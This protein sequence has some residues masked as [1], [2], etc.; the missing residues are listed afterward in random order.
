GDMAQ[1]LA[2]VGPVGLQESLAQRRRHHA[3]LGLGDI[4][5]SIAHPMHAGAVEEPLWQPDPL[6]RTAQAEI[7]FSVVGSV[8]SRTCRGE[9]LRHTAAN[10]TR[11]AVASRL[12][13]IAVAVSSA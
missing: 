10:M 2:G 5:K 4:S 7:A 6:I 9:R 3:L 1:Y 11:R 13:L 12:R 8:W